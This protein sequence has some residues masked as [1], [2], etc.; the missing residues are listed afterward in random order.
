MGQESP[1]A[2]EPSRKLLTTGRRP[3]NSADFQILTVSSPLS[4]AARYSIHTSYPITLWT[5][6]LLPGGASRV[7]SVAASACRWTPVGIMV[8]GADT[9]L[10]KARKIRGVPDQA[11][12]Q[13]THGSGPEAT[14][15]TPLDS[16]A[17]GGLAPGRDG[18]Q[19]GAGSVPRLA[20]RRALKNWRVRSRLFL[21][22]VIPTVTA[23][24]GGAIFIAS[25]AQNAL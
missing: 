25:S 5:Q 2:G 3:A 10:S 7:G 12:S 14:G 17:P 20:S 15:A 23:V 6:N 19:P 8:R 24:V 13:M 9:A 18:S 21:L 22:V 4:I 16:P 1:I 11:F